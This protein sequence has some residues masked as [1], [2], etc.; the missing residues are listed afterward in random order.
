V[1]ADL[2]SVELGIL[3]DIA[4]FVID[5]PEGRQLLVTKENGVIAHQ[6]T[7]SAVKRISSQLGEELDIKRVMRLLKTNDLV[8]EGSSGTAGSVSGPRVAVV[9][10]EVMDH[11]YRHLA[12]VR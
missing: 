2:S 11:L 10:R 8:E 5:S 7:I 4:K 3:R 1:L 6:G 12:G 9:T